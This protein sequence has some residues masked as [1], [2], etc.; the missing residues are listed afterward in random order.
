VPVPK[1]T[2]EF[3][4]LDPPTPMGRKRTAFR[5]KDGVAHYPETKDVRSVY[6]IRHA[7]IGMY[8]EMD[9]AMWQAKIE[10]GAARVL[11]GATSLGADLPAPITGA[12]KL[13]I[14][15][16]HKCP[17]VMSL[18]KRQA[19]WMN[20]TAMLTKPDTNNVI[21]QVCDALTGYAYVDDK[22]VTEIEAV[23]YYAVD[24]A[25]NHTGPRMTIVV[26]EL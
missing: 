25:G 15:L 4:V 12:V 6:H 19:V 20:R 8:P 10:E 17:T 14:R 24:Q 21:N 16:W 1:R 13:T 9:P 22:Q 11:A 18:K 7:F 3:T 2:F 23:K 5:G 26:E